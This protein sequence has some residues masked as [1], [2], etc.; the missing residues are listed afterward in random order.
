MFILVGCRAAPV[1][2]GYFL[3][4]ALPVHTACIVRVIQHHVR[5]SA[6]FR[7]ECCCVRSTPIRSITERPSLSPRSST[8]SPLGSPYGLLSQPR[9][10][11]GWKGYG[12]TTFRVRT[13]VGWVSPLRRWRTICVR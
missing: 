5:K 12:L 8:R 4:T 1:A 10:A 6:R 3:S 13:C 7:V 2:Q 11:C 9:H